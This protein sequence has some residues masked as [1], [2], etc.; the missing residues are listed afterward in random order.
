MS[1][2]GGNTT[3]YWFVG[4]AVLLFLLACL[5]VVA[6]VSWGLRRHEA[7]ITVGDGARRRLE[8][9][10][11]L[12]TLWGLSASVL[13]F[14]ASALLV[15]THILALL[16]VALLAAGVALISLG[17]AVAAGAVGGD[18]APALGQDASDV[19]ATLRLGLWMLF[20]A[21]WLPVLGWIAV[22]L[23][24]ASGLGAMLETLLTRE[25][26]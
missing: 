26:A 23:A 1:P 8:R 13:I 7:L 24:G 3:W 22:I 2:H 10:R 19:L 9:G 20:L 4:P 18:V 16:G 6:L 5:S 11:A 25:R 12:P 17:I 15:R 14:A 21:A